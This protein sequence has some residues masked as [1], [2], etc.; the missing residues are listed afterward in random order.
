[1]KRIKCFFGIHQAITTV[2]KYD[3]I[4]DMEVVGYVIMKLKVCSR[5]NHAEI[6]VEKLYL[7]ISLK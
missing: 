3:L 7:P 6:S 4:R 5:C 2:T 1:M